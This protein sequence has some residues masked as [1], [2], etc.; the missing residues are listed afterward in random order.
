[1]KSADLSPIAQ[2]PQNVIDEELF[3]D[4]NEQIELEKFIS[5]S[6]VQTNMQRSNST[7]DGFQFKLPIQKLKAG[8]A[9]ADQ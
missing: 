2:S 9:S 8:I 4:V 6:K 7:T 1:M 5:E 3:A